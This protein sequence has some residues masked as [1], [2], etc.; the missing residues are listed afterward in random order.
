VLLL[1]ERADAQDYSDL[2]EMLR[3]WQPDS[4]NRLEKLLGKYDTLAAS[5]GFVGE[6]LEKAR[7][8]LRSL[9]GSDGRACLLGLADYLASQTDALGREPESSL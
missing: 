5:H 1:R 7:A 4:M 3:A 9:P 8:I 6:Y 2:M